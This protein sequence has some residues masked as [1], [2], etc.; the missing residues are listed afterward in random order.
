MGY[1]C[2]LVI[3][4]GHTWTENGEIYQAKARRFIACGSQGSTRRLAFL[5]KKDAVFAA[6]SKDP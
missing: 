3:Q 5:E 2:K 6:I 1:P 4:S